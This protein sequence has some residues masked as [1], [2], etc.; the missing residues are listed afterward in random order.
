MESYPI[1]KFN[2]SSEVNNWV[3]VD[4]VVMGGK[5]SG[6]FSLN[7]DGHGVFSGSISLENM[8]GF[9]MLRYQFRK[10]N[11]NVFTRIR[12]KLKGDGKMYQFRIKNNSDNYYS[13]VSTFS[14]SGDWEEIEIPLAEMYP[15]FRGKKLNQA[16]FP[17]DYLAE[18][19]FLI[20]NKKTE[21]FRLLIDQIDL[22]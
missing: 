9:S 17:G 18:V 19:S 1:F 13:Y 10:I 20:G 7:T 3:I 16:N 4:D 11:V 15:A 14:T 5:S 22:L 21:K 2:K 12:I 6:N 8:G